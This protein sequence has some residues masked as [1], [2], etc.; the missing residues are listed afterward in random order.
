MF[1]ILSYINYWLRQVDEHSLHSPFLFE[2]YQDLIKNQSIR[3]SQPIEALRAELKKNQT[4]FLFKELGAGS[5]VNSS[6]Y[7]Q[8][9]SIAKYSTTPVKFSTF[10]QALIEKYQ[11]TSVLELGT[12]LGIN[13]LYLAENKEVEVIT[14]EGEP[15]IAQ[16]AE[17]HFLDLNKENVELIHQSIETVI[18]DQLLEKKSFDLIYLDAH[19]EY[20]PSLKYF[21][22]F[23]EKLSTKGVFIIDDIHWSKGMNK[24]WHEIRNSDRVSLSIDLFEAGLIFLDPELPKQHYILKF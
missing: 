23:S 1:Q 16:L 8:V 19:H 24:A 11:Y 5:R 4:K 2:F 20:E 10:L 21:Q 22:Y 17:Q 13:T 7:R 15:T 14:I 6:A 9:S 18:S 3:A 12:S